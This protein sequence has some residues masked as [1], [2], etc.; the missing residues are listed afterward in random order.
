M[1][2]HKPAVGNLFPPIELPVLSGGKRS[3]SEPLQG[4]DWQLSVVYRGKH[5]P[6]CTNYLKDLNAALPELNELGVDVLAVSADSE[7]RAKAQMAEVEPN[8]AVGYGLTVEQMHTLGLYVSG[9]RNGIDVEGP[10]AEP[11]LF[12]INDVGRLQMVDVSN[13][14]FAR[15][16]LPTIVRGLRFVRGATTPF[17]INGT[18]A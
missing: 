17:P 8:F 6:L 12:V 16:H 18:Y 11:G 2:L 5:C 1:I 4:F 7:K 9:P 13:V 15:P 3:L 14:P 10:F